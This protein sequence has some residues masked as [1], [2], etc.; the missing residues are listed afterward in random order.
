MASPTFTN[1]PALAAVL[2]ATTTTEADSVPCP[3]CGLGTTENFVPRAPRI[4]EKVRGPLGTLLPTT[5]RTV[6]L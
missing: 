1:H 6:V 3:T 5:C 4:H 2:A